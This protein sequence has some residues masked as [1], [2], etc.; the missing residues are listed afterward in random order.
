MVE[1]L[2]DWGFRLSVFQKPLI[3]IYLLQITTFGFDAAVG[4]AAE[5][6]DRIHTTA[7]SHHRIIT[8]E[9]MGRYAGFLGQRIKYL[10]LMKKRSYIDYCTK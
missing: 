1:I 9:I 8:V 5:A 4:V 10:L 2:P 7:E 6:L 3:M